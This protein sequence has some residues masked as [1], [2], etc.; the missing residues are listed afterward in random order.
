M[1]TSVQI[2]T[3]PSLSIEYDGIVNLC[4]E[5]RWTE[6]YVAL[7]NQFSH[8]LLTEKV[9][10]SDS[11]HWLRSANIRA[12]GLVKGELLCGVALLYLNKG[13]EFCFFTHQQG[14]GIGH[15]L[16]TLIEK[17]A[18][19]IHLSKIWA[20]TLKNNKRAITCFVNHGFE[21]TQATHRYYQGKT[22]EG[23]I[24]EKYL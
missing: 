4:R 6:Q 1:M 21:L 13:S 18:T 14:K 11:R 12:I 10:V 3:K 7:R 24:F 5:Q 19:Q 20:W 16:L 8:L 2:M 23:V 9:N 22:L 15:Q 17:E